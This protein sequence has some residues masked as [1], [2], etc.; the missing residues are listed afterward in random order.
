VHLFGVECPGCGM[1]RAL[2]E[3]LKGNFMESLE[4]YPAL[5]PMVLL[6]STLIVHLV[7]KLKYGAEILKYLFLFTVL[8]IV[9]SYIVKISSLF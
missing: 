8:I 9:V 6:F 5:L 2:I 4:L 3:L 7:F 1:Q